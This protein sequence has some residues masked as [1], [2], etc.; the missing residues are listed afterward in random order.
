[1]GRWVAR[2]KRPQTGGRPTREGEKARTSG[3]HVPP[4]TPIVQ[5][6]NGFPDGLQTEAGSTV[7]KD[8]PMKD[9]N[10]K[11]RRWS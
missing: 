11:C 6:N 10:D 1:M 3:R 5:S 4:Y 2:P 9:G 8:V 7:I